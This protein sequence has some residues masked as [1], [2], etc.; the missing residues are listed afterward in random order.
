MASSTSLPTYGLAKIE[1]ADILPSGAIGT[2]WTQVGYTSQGSCKLVEAEPSITEFV[3]EESDSPLVSIYK[4]GVTELQ[5]SIMDA[6]P[7]I[8][9]KI[10][11]GTAT[12][13]MPN[14]VWAAPLAKAS[15]E[16]SIKITP[17]SGYIITIPRALIS[18]KINSEF[19]SKNIMLVDLKASVLIPS[20][21]TSKPMTWTES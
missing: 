17:V 10:L 11:G 2:T 8:L 4:G 20:D 19:S 15:I 13:S 5:F 16:Q 12:G 14:R 1:I 3:P 9:A 18:G 7:T 6:T 21:G